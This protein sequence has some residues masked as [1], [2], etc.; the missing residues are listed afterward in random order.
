MYP[1]DKDIFYGIFAKN[2]MN[3]E[4]VV[5]YGKGKTKIEKIKKYFLF[6]FNITKKIRSNNF[7]LIYVHYMCLNLLPFFMS[8]I[9]SIPLLNRRLNE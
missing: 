2:G 7:N 1:S 4:K 5:M 9:F 8:I 3:I 6:Y